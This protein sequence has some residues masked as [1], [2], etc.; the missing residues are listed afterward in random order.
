MCEAP[1]GSRYPLVGGT[2]GR[3]FD[4]IQLEL[5]KRP[6]NAATSTATPG[7][8][9]AAALFAGDRSRAS[10]SR[11]PS[12][13]RVGHGPYNLIFAAQNLKLE[14]D[15][16]NRADPRFHSIG[17]FSHA[18]A[19]PGH[20]LSQGII[21]LQSC[22]ISAFSFGSCNMLFHLMDNQWTHRQ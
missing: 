17:S 21:G 22:L 11:C 7:A 19:E 2:R 13:R 12:G 14:T 15:P 9:V 20:D 8:S 3:H 5:G 18:N 1:N 10:L 16:A 4:G 6:E